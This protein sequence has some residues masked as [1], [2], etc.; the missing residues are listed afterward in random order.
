MS[1]FKLTDMHGAYRFFRHP[2]PLMGAAIRAE[3]VRNGHLH[4]VR[5]LFTAQSSDTRTGA[6]DRNTFGYRP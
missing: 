2:R 3:G 4:H 1:P 5:G 6:H